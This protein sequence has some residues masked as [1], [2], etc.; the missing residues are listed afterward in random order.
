M[1][2]MDNIDDMDL[3]DSPSSLFD[4]NAIFPETQLESVDTPSV[5]QDRPLSLDDMDKAIEWEAKRL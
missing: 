3:M 1:D 5:Y 4:L 2:E